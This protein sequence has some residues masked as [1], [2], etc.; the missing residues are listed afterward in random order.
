MLLD[1]S[2]ICCAMQLQ[3]F[4]LV[5]DD[6]MDNSVTRR[7]QPCWYR[8]PEVPKSH[9]AVTICICAWNAVNPFRC[10]DFHQARIQLSG[11]EHRRDGLV[12]SPPSGLSLKYILHAPVGW[13]N[14]NK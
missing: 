14:C 6:L 9:G 1:I 7:G 4:F 5:S 12:A 13:N 11:P 8:M 3:A 2:H 10:H